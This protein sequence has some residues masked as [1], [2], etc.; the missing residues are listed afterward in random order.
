MEI[1]NNIW[2]AI[3]TPNE[4]LISLLLIPATLIE[5]LLCL[6]LIISV[7]NI[8]IDKKQKIAYVLLT[9][10]LGLIGINVI[11][12][13]FNFFINYILSMIIVYY[14]LKQNILHSILIVLLSTGSFALVGTLVLN[15]YLT[16]LNITYE[17][18]ETIPLYRLGYFT[19]MYSTIFIA[20]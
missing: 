4:G 20:L 17:Q 6:L 7:L 2:M 19:L 11:P 13:P 18:S 14:I 10:V 5:N 1:L 8:T 3:S 12:Q 15:P 16:L 9:S